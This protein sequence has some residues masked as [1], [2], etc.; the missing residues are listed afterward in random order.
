MKQGYLEKKKNMVIL[1]YLL[2]TDWTRKDTDRLE[3][4]VNYWNC[5]LVDRMRLLRKKK[6][7]AVYCG[8][9]E[10]GVLRG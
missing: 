10:C 6:R 4:C 3:M 1:T 2:K 5:V 8:D 7:V 9:G